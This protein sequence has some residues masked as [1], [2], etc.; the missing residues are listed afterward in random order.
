MTRRPVTSFGG[1]SHK[2]SMH[3]YKHEQV[4]RQPHAI[5]RADVFPLLEWLNGAQ[6]AD[7]L[8][9]TEPNRARFETIRN[10]HITRSQSNCLEQQGKIY[11]PETN[12]CVSIHGKSGMRA[13]A[14]RD[15]SI[16]PSPKRCQPPKILNPASYKCVKPDGRVGKRLHNMYPAMYEPFVLPPKRCEDWQIL[17]P[18]TNRCVK[19]DGKAGYK[20]LSQMNGYF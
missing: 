18:D 14:I 7:I 10:Q 17:N 6:D 9:Q 5:G 8:T 11:N 20:V 13:M 16:D 2:Q 4:K 15:G 19:R 3:R 12:R 1:G